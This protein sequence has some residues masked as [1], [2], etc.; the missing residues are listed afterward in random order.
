MTFQGLVG[1]VANFASIIT[2]IVAISVS[3]Y[4]WWKL[5]R[6][7]CL[8]ENYLKGL[9]NNK[10][11]K[12]KQRTLVSL[13][14]ALAITEADILQAA[15]DSNRVARR[16]KVDPEGLATELLLEYKPN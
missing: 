11:C 3:S 16:V 6:K 8:L 2:A 14:A 10:R 12:K 15:F 9:W 13:S 7:R 5:R 1:I 4:Y